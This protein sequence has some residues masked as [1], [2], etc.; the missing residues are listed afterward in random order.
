MTAIEQG[1]HMQVIL[2]ILFFIASY[3]AADW[4][5]THFVGSSGLIGEF[6]VN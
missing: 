5:V 6:F 1:Q 2:Q 3:F 4:T